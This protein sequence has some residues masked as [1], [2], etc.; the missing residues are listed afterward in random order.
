MRQDKAAD[1]DPAVVDEI[2]R[3]LRHAAD[4]GVAIPPIRNELAA[5]G[6]A[7]AYAVQDANTRHH[8]QQGRRL[9]GR[10]IGLTAKA[11]QAQLG[12][13]QPDFGALFAEM[14]MADG[15]EVPRSR[16]MQ[17]K[18]EAEIALVLE[19]DLDRDQLG[20]TD[21]LS[22]LAYA[23]P[24]IEIVGSRIEDWNID[25]LDTVADNASSGLFVLGAA[26]VKIDRLDWRL[27]GMVMEKRGQ[28]VSLGAGAACLGNP[29][30]AALWLARK[31]VSIG[32]PMKAGDVILTG[33][34]GPMATV[35][36]GDVFVARVNGL[37]SVRAAF[38]A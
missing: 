21:L 23:L 7:A 2:A 20:L 36:P 38:G 1:L 27:C 28:Q 13:D 8:V 3:R 37:G 5:G 4:S 16:V 35:S 34:L 9:V 17:P 33:A 29:L 10:K 31:M 24:A 25:L 11:V 6:I 32:S 30:N 19:R 12:V 22:A 18:V 14:E 15:D 26:P